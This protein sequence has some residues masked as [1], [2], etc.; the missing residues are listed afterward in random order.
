MSKIWSYSNNWTN[1]VDTQHRNKYF[2]REELIV[3]AIL[4]T[5]MIR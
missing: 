1:I 2:Y 3:I 4:F 5:D